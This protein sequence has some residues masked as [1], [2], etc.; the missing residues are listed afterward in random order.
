MDQENKEINKDDLKEE[1]KTEI[2]RENKKESKQKKEGLFK[3]FMKNT[4]TKVK[5]ILLII[6]I[7]AII[8][9]GVLV[10]T[11]LNSKE[12]LVDFGFK[13][14]GVLV[15]QEWYGKMLEVSS[16]DRKIFDTISVPFTES[17][18]IF[19]MDVKV[20]AGINFSE[21]EYEVK[22]ENNQK[23]IVV[24]L[25]HSYIYQK[26]ADDSTFVS[27]LESESWF[28]NI[29]STDQQKLKAKITEEGEKKA[30][31]SG[32][33]DKADKNAENLIRNMIKSNK[34]TKDYEVEFEYK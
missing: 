1:I 18:I 16:K 26:A 14:V 25:P 3:L 32:I 27:Y 28:T 2:E 29:N 23:K 20:L 5:F 8:I 13:N 33:L 11:K 12:V 9:L 34:T 10:P 19:S 6:I 30:I 21:I 7:V 4:S 15:T 31:E 24:K 22:K 17:K